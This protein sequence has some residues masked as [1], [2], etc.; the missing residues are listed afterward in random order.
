MSQHLLNNP[1][2]RVMRA[3]QIDDLDE[4]MRIIDDARESI[5]S[6]GIA[7]WTD[8][9]PA[10]KHI[11]RDIDHGWSYVLLDKG[12]IVGTL[13]VSFDG[14]PAYDTIFDGSWEYYGPFATVHRVAVSPQYRGRG[15]S[16]LLFAGAEALALAREIRV[17]RV[18]T[19]EG[20]IPM[21][22][23]LE[24]SGYKRAGTIKLETGALRVAYEKMIT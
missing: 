8:E 1:Q 24:R 10:R 12:V 2:T 5:K 22:R 16:S 18:D 7:Q 11:A 17:V 23:A 21:R 6:L 9:Y 19:H 14:E 20:N 4:I 3:A 15:F 13:A